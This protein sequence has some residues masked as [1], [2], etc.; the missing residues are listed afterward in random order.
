LV[1][2]ER[3]DRPEPD[4]PRRQGREM[5][6]AAQGAQV[7]GVI[8]VVRIVDQAA[9]MNHPGAGEVGQEVIGPDLVAFGR[10]E[11]KSMRKEQQLGQSPYPR[12][13][14]ISGPSAFATARGRRRQIA[15]KT[16]YLGFNGLISGRFEARSRRYS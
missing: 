1:A 7:V 12:P 16:A 9:E 3:G 2:G 6:F 11:R 8:V 13:R 5:A 10:R 15:M 14:E 4:A